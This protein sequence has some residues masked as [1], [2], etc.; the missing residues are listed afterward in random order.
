MV[1]YHA[2]LERLL[3]DA[4]K[5]LMM[6]PMPIGCPPGDARA[7]WPPV[8]QQY[9]D[10]MGVSDEG[11]VDDRQEALAQVK[12]AVKLH[13]SREQVTRLDQVLGFLLLI[14]LPH[15]RKTVMARMLTHPVSGLPVFSWKQIAKT[16]GT[17][18]EAVRHWRRKGIDEILWKRAAARRKK[19]LTHRT[20]ST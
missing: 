16:M 17:S 19:S 7:V 10:L 8:L 18:K 9:W 5:T 4:G 14:S 6:L 3:K 12:N 13:A 11:S 15:H 20:H 1:D 2:D